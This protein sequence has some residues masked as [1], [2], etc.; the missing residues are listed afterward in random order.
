MS[1][2]TSQGGRQI[3]DVEKK[4]KKVSCFDRRVR[5]SAAVAVAIETKFRSLEDSERG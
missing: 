5:R 2:S 4:M 1:G 3:E